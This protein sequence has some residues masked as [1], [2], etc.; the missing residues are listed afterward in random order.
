MTTAAFI[1]IDFA[2][3]R[4]QAVEWF[5]LRL[6]FRT[7]MT[8]FALNTL[9]IHGRS[10]LK[11]GYFFSSDFDSTSQ[12]CQGTAEQETHRHFSVSA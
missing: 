5:A 11:G 4:R 6:D 1:T 2:S 9:N 3:P 12:A 10:S 7:I 8:S